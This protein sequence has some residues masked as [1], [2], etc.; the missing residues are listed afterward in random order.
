[1][2]E[3]AAIEWAVIPKPARWEL[4]HS[5]SGLRLRRYCAV[6]ERDTF[7]AMV[8]AV[9]RLRDGAWFSICRPCA[10]QIAEAVEER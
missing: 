8:L 3:L 2:S 10:E 9:S 1:M 5:A 7:R 6:C 4:S